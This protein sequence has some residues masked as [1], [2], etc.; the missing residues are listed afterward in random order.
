MLRRMTSDSPPDAALEAELLPD[1]VHPTNL[2]KRLS[3]FRVLLLFKFGHKWIVFQ[4]LAFLL[5]YFYGY[6]MERCNL[7]KTNP[8]S[9]QTC[10]CHRLLLR[11]CPLT[12]YCCGQ[13]RW[14]NYPSSADQM[15]DISASADQTQALC[16]LICR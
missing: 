4:Y 3:S 15:F 14:C 9:V 5:I 16:K 8:I 2:A 10:F 7:T 6:Q 12:K 1:S 11:N 13:G